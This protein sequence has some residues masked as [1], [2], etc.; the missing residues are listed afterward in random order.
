MM[1]DKPITIDLDAIGLDGWIAFAE[2]S[3]QLQQLKGRDL[4]TMAQA[5]R[6]AREVLM[7]FLMP[8]WGEEEI[9]ALNIAEVKA[10]MTRIGEGMRGPNLPSGTPSTP[11]T[12]TR[13]DSPSAPVSRGRPKRGASRPGRLRPR[14]A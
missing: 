11:R 14:S 6:G 13:D 2:A 1:P 8:A 5:L 3:T 12:N 4:A 9:G 7:V 10:V